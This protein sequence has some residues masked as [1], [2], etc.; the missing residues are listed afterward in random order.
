MRWSRTSRRASTTGASRSSASSATTSSSKPIASPTA[1]TSLRCSCCGAPRA[2]SGTRGRW[3]RW[4]TTAG[5]AAF[6]VPAVGR[7]R[8][9]VKAWVDGFLTWR[10]DFERRVDEAD[11]RLAARS[12]AELAL[13]PRA[14]P[15]TTPGARLAD[16]ATQLQNAVAAGVDVATLR[17]LALDEDLARLAMRWPDDRFA[18]VH[19]RPNCRWWP[20]ANARASRPGTSS[21]RARRR[22][23]RGGTARSP[24]ARRGCPTSPTWASTSS[25]FRRSIR[26]AGCNRKG[27]N[28][29]LVPDGGRRRQPVGH[30]RRRRRAPRDPRAARHARRLRRAGRCGAPRARSRGRARH[31]L[32]VRARPSLRARAPGLVPQAA[33]RQRPV[34]GEPAEEVPGH[35]SVRLRERRVACAVGRADRGHG[36]LDRTRRQDLPRRQSAHQG[37]SRS[38]SGRS[39]DSRPS[40][41]TCCSSPRRSRDRRSCTAWPSSASR[42]ATPTS[43]GATP[44]RNSPSTSPSSRSARAATTSGPTC[45]RTRRTS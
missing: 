38:G 8:Y 43:P 35:L 26:S 24:T 10:H 2:T 3:R 18:C 29:S 19:P 41:P 36:L 15:A 7:Y 42:R 17:A 23:S 22:R 28:N 33:R 13:P 20:T 21:S 30:R 16:W 37:A 6:T 32:P 44:G 14:A 34:R 25:T 12:G 27:R 11:L 40:I 4:A 39:R 31:R 45:G 5:A 9:T 1:T